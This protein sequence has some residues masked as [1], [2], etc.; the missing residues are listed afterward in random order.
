LKYRRTDV[1]SLVQN[2]HEDG[3]EVCFKCKKRVHCDFHHIMNGSKH[4]K[5]ISEKLGA[6]IWLCPECHRWLHGTGEG[7]Q[8]QRTL[9]ALVQERYE[10]DHSRKEWMAMIHKNYREE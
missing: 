2:D 8:Y 4:L 1:P 3:E 9:K 7:A 6:W 5:Y 10:E